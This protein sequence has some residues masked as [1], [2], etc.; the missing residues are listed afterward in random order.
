MAEKSS[1]A[2]PHRRMRK[3]ESVGPISVL[4]LPSPA[5]LLAEA[6]AQLKAKAPR[7]RAQQRGR[8]AKGKKGRF[9]AALR[10][11]WGKTKLLSTDA[12]AGETSYW[13]SSRSLHRGKVHRATPARRPARKGEPA[14]PMLRVPRKKEKG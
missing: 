5:L 1:Q 13:A 11:L 4:P 14:D 6:E 9:R 7:L 12:F 2:V 8:V 10:H 3:P